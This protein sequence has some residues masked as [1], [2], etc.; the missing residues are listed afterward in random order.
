VTGVETRQVFDLPPMRLGVVEHR[1]RAALLPLRGHHRRGL[2][3]QARAAACYGPGLRALV[4]IS[5]TS[6]REVDTADLRLQDSRYAPRSRC[7]QRRVVG[8]YTA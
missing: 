8:S 1:A 5:W 2:P 7:R 6:P 3:A 4:C